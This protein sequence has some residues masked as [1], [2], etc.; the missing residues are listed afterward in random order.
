[1]T[2]IWSLL[3]EAGLQNLKDNMGKIQETTISRFDG[4]VVNDPRDP[5]ESVAQVVSNFDILTD[6]Y[7]MKPYRDSESG[8][9]NAST[10]TIRNFCMARRTG[11]TYSLYGL[12]ITPGGGIAEVYYKDITTGGSNDLG[13]N[14]WTETAN[15]A[16]ASGA[17]N[18]N[19]FVFYRYTTVANSRIFGASGG[20]RIWS[21][22]PTGTV[23][24]DDAGRNITY[25]NIAQ[26]VVHPKDDI[27]Y[28][29]YDNKIAKNSNGS[30]TDTALTLPE[31]H[32]ITSISPFGNYL[33]I[34]MAP[35]SAVGDSL[36]YLWDRDATLATLSD[37][38][39]WGSETLQIIEEIDGLLIGISY[40]GNNT[41][42]NNQRVVF[43]Y[44]NGSNASKFREYTAGSGTIVLPIAKRKENNRLYFL[45]QLSIN[46][47]TRE[48]VWSIG[49][50][51]DEW[52]VTH[53]RTP[54]NDTALAGSNTLYD[55]FL[56]G[57][58]M[59]ITY[60]TSGSVGMSKTNDQSS[61]TATS[62]Y[63]SKIFNDGDASLK[64]K[65]IG[66]TVM[67]E[68]LPAAGSVVLKYKKDEETSYTTIFTDT[69]DNDISHSA[70]NIE[71]SGASLPEYKEISFRIESTGGA[72]ITGLSWMSNNVGKRT[73]AALW[74]MVLR[75]GASLI[76]K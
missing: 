74:E 45:M 50:T 47:S 22:D 57:D 28:I 3:Y 32:Y 46:G 51:R 6:P 18:F 43:R 75:W 19:L 70:V 67:F 8:H 17:T 5:R 38:I 27:L 35:L 12:G 73:Y 26:G 7:R 9:D 15:N 66:A 16:A 11:T 65:L 63:E 58:Y 61:F 20:T 36:V 25:T 44:L 64:K 10:E 33:A 62:I 52:T 30:W 56:V 1:M 24:F 4:G 60:L 59:F 21:Y 42:R 34:A 49:R 2:R 53:E 40:A 31:S 68:A 39:N 54:N 41:I 29:P 55:F 69:T 48:G 14:G 72:V 71:S 13:D 76:S 23:A 37:V